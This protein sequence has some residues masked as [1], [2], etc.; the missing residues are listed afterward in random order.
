MKITHLSLPAQNLD[1]MARFYRAT[2]ALP[3]E[4]TPS[5][6][7]VRVGAATLEFFEGPARPQH[8]AFNVSEFASAK[9]WLASRVPLHQDAGGHDEFDFV[10][11]AARGA[12][13]RDPDGNILE[14]IAR[15][16]RHLDADGHPLAELSEVGIACQDVAGAVDRVGLPIYG[17]ASPGFTAVGDEQGLLILVS[18]GRLW[19]PDTGIPATSVVGEVEF[20]DAGV[21]HRLDLREFVR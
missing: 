4:T 3:V 5:G 14:I 13:F 12:Y 18:E 11:W 15:S 1:A 2:L 21:F 17:E 8:F 6:F 9:A 16:T 10:T 20:A 7:T 19:Y